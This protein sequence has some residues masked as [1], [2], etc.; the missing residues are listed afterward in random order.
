MKNQKI[1]ILEFLTRFKAGTAA[2]EKEQGWK[3]W[4]GGTALVIIAYFSQIHHLVVERCA[5]GISISTWLIR[6]VASLVLLFYCIF[7]REFL[8]CV[9]QSVNIAAI[10]ITIV[11]VLSSNRVCTFHLKP[12]LERAGA[13]SCR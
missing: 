10:L 9:V 1:D 8:L 3:S 11:L 2:I 12:V 5:W 13:G 7:R 6:L 4:L